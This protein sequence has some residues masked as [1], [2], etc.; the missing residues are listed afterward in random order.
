MIDGFSIDL[1][2]VSDIILNKKPY[3]IAPEAIQRVEKSYS[4]LEKFSH[5]KLIYGLNTGFGPMAQYRIPTEKMVELQYNL[6]RSHA[7]GVGGYL[8]PLYCKSIL[9]NLMHAMMRGYS[10]IHP[11][12]IQLL[13]RLLDEDIIPCVPMHGSVGAS[14]DLV[15]M[16]HVALA[17]IGEGEVYYNNEVK[18]AKEV[19][20][21]KG[22]EPFKI[23]LRDGLGVINGTT[24]MTGVAALNTIFAQ[25]A[26]EWS[27]ALSMMIN[28]MMES[29]DDHVSKE[30][31]AVK[32]QSGQQVIAEKAR[33]LLNG[34]QLIKSRK[35]HLYEKEVTEDYIEHKVQ[36]YYSLRC[37]PQI[38][39]PVY[40]TILHAQQIVEN[41]L[42]ST[43]D[44]P[45]V[46]AEAGS[47]YH[48]G[49]FHGD[50]IS[51]EMDKMKLAV[52]RICMLAE[53]QLNYLLNDK[54]NN[55]LTPFV[56]NGTLGLNFGFQGIQ[57]TATSTTAEAQA[58][59]TSMYVHS[60][61]NNNDN[62]DIVSMGFN[63]SCMA[64]RVIENTFEVMAI[65]AATV[66]QGIEQL[67]VVDKLSP[68]TKKIYTQIREQYPAILADRSTSK[69]TERLKNYMK[70]NPLHIL[71]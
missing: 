3:T 1:S 12:L 24:A 29:Y 26:A 61:P 49:N 13:K 39:G 22:I 15:Q 2:Q 58:M 45:V 50:Y 48:G 63:S 65:E 47:V 9:L 43:S 37:V 14:G 68:M 19:F 41:E 71:F 20:E 42:N 34:S 51:L 25:R 6:I 55:R 59:S 23:Y 66:A 35:N 32:R 21:Q 10:G 16:S 7:S 57:F 54:I 46:D 40:D 5:K 30:L 69:D 27:L 4:F 18:S 67:K 44:N 11:S 38:L 53:R 28:E 64:K 62:Q 60:I 8:E 36:E 70:N 52:V 56:N 31:S 17:L 33:E